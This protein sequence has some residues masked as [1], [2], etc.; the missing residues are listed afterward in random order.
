MRTC[1]FS[2]AGISFGMQNSPQRFI[3]TEIHARG[4]SPSRGEVMAQNPSLGQDKPGLSTLASRASYLELVDEPQV[5]CYASYT[6]SS[7]QESEDYELEN[8]TSDAGRPIGAV[9]ALLSSPPIVAMASDDGLVAADLDNALEKLCAL[10][11][12]HPA[13]GASTPSKGICIRP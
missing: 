13:H 3:K 2:S 1:A 8:E 9:A 12:T 6:Q 5:E 4:T 7:D 10:A 11:P